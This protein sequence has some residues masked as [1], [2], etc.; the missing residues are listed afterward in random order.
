MQRKRIGFAQIF[1]QSFFISLA[2]L[3]IRFIE[4][5]YVVRLRSGIRDFIGIIQ[6]NLAKT[7]IFFCMAYE[8]ICQHVVLIILMKNS[9]LCSKC[10]LVQI[11]ETIFSIPR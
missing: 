7:E 10:G 8:D 2:Y 6:M 3:L 11:V 9:Q 5:N 4:I 1:N